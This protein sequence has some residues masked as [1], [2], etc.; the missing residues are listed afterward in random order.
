VLDSEGRVSDFW[1]P[2][3]EKMLGWNQSEVMGE[4]YPI[5]NTTDEKSKQA[6]EQKVSEK[7]GTVQRIIEKARKDGSNGIF[8][9]HIGPIIEDQDHMLVLV[10]DITKE[11]EYEQRLRNSLKEKESLLAEIHHR[12]K[13]NLA[14]ITSLIELQKD[15]IAEPKLQRS[16]DDTQSRIYSIAGVHELL[17]DADSFSEIDFKSYIDRIINKLVHIYTCQEAR[18]GISLP[19]H[20]L[21][22]DINRAVPLG[23]LLNEL[24]ST[25]FKKMSLSQTNADIHLEVAQTN[26]EIT[27]RYHDR[28]LNA[29]DYAEDSGQTEQPMLAKTLM[30]TLLGQLNAQYEFNEE[31]GFGVKF[32]FAKARTF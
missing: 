17:Y 1:N 30:I 5:L 24:L 16:L 14:I 29:S 21:S 18:I 7:A 26:E 32:Q 12:V 19:E 2:A 3:A 10:E 13:N 9:L 8:R 20:D 25:S 31:Q 15:E 23:M 22:I 28:N 6:L 27:I 4:K 11:K